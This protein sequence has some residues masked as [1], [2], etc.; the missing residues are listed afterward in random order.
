MSGDIAPPYI[1]FSKNPPPFHAFHITDK[2]RDNG[3]FIVEDPK[4][5]SSQHDTF[6]NTIQ[7]Y[8]NLGHIPT[9]NS[10]SVDEH[11]PPPPPPPQFRYFWKTARSP[12][13]NTTY[14]VVTFFFLSFFVLLCNL[15]N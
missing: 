1:I 15:D 2:L 5:T 11:P 10:L 3:Y 8:F 14:K 13:S 6:I 4:Y 7:T 9:N 12:P